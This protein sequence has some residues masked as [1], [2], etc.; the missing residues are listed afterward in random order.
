MKQD[1]KVTI[2]VEPERG[3]EITTGY[4]KLPGEARIVHI[5]EVYRGPRT[6]NYRFARSNGEEASRTVLNDE[7]DAARRVSLP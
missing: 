4:Y 3:D 2:V 1:M 5:F 6:T 7:P